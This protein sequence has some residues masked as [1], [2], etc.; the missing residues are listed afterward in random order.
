MFLSVLFA[1]MLYDVFLI[2]TAIVGFIF[3][4]ISIVQN[5]SRD[6]RP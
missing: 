2:L 1:S 4:L 6:K 3:L 5:A